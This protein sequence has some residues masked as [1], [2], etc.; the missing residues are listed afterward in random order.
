[1][2]IF[3]SYSRADSD[4]AERLQD[5]IRALNYKTWRDVDNIR[6]GENWDDAID[7][8]LNRSD[9][10]VGVLSPSSVASTSVKN[11]WA[12]ALA[13][14]RPLILLFYQPCA[15]P[16][17]Y[18]RINYV[19]FTQ[20]KS[21]AFEQLGEA[22]KNPARVMSTQDAP[23]PASIAASRHVGHDD[24]NGT[25]KVD[26]DDII[27]DQRTMLVD[28]LL[29]ELSLEQRNR[30]ILL[31]KVRTFW[32]KGVL[33]HSLHGAA[34]VALEM[35]EDPNAV[36]HPWGLVMRTLNWETELLPAGTH[37]IDLFEQ[38]GRSLLILGDPGS[39]KTT[40]LLELARDAIELAE[41][42]PQEPI[43]VVFNLSSW[44]EATPTIANWV[45]GELNDKYL[46][47]QE[48]GKAFVKNEKLLLLLDGLDEV[49]GELRTACVDAI[50]QF[51]RDYG[52]TSIVVCS[53]SK[54][55]QTLSKQLKLEGAV[56][57]QPLTGN[58][59]DDYLQGAGP[60]LTTLRNVLKD[61]A[62]LQEMAQSP[63]ILSIMTLAYSDATI[64][65]LSSQTSLEARRTHL[66][67]AYIDRMFARRPVN[68][69]YS[70]ED[71]IRWL[72][73][74]AKQMLG[75]S[76][77]VFLIEG[78]QPSWL[79]TAQ[80]RLRY[81]LGTRI[82]GGV[83][84]AAMLS[85]LAFTGEGLLGTWIGLMTKNGSAGFGVGLG[86][87]AAFILAICGLIVGVLMVGSSA[88]RDIKLVRIRYVVMARSSQRFSRRHGGR[89]GRRDLKHIDRSCSKRS[90]P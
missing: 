71:T 25:L 15:I 50:N 16:H 89:T 68:Q 90:S 38:L 47:L 33:E 69:R 84:A 80:Q 29:H 78:L 13:N 86:L 17:R 61:D 81:S 20:N 28:A 52:L 63:L 10:V 88:K 62:L 42:E 76:Q 18:V 36:D 7:R 77:M 30:R 31:Q 24:M 19:D 70:R 66:F 79:S 11:E 12:W 54:D 8:G 56:V 53:R 67:N 82:V 74:L 2:Q 1:M 45:I 32:I 5:R 64:D 51:R 26:G 65:G 59:I 14:E 75:R 39:G 41:S 60:K 46:V 55:Y 58:Q 9:V 27:F 40:T 44:C 23:L 83:V 43:P 37:I 49:R 34:L 85:A 72:A 22:L 21:A 3:I 4:F 57:L 73:W 35:Q 6:Q 87:V 48:I